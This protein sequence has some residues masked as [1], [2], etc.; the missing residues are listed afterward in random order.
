MNE[1]RLAIDTQALA[2]Y[3]APRIEGLRG[4]LRAR[5]FSG[6]QSN[7]TYLLEAGELRLVLRRKPPGELLPKAHMIEREFEV[8]R[9]LGAAGFPVPKMRLLCEDAA[10]I[11]APFYV[12]D[13]VEGRVI[14]ETAMPDQAPEERRET[15]HALIDRLAALHR[16]DP[17]ALGLAAFG[18]PGGYLT[19][20]T[21]VWSRQYRAAA[22]AEIPDMERLMRWLPN[23][24]S[25][26]PDETCLVHGDY[27]LDNA[28]FHP[29]RPEILAVLDWELSTLGHPLSDLAYFLMTWAFP[30]DL[31]HGLADVDCAALGIPEMSELAARYAE[32]TGRR[33]I[34]HLDALLAFSAFRMAAI[35]QGVYRRGL[36]GNAS[37]DA[38]LS[39]G[40]DV[41]RLA[42]VAWDHATRAGL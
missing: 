38:A 15:F 11:G 30:S 5:Q 13:H 24:I 41:R 27:R 12:M 4:H 7:P 33:D 18:K 3:L 17:V 42:A 37:D 6:G 32:A 23:A 19:R 20:Q 28:I 14:F 34:P 9:A 31:R 40:G 10:V 16:L 21:S 1:T 25:A 39:M 22:T 36:D 35:I 29:E 8:M 26:I 2:V